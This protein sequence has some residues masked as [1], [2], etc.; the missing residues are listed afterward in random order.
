M[1]IL[2]TSNYAPPHGGVATTV[3]Y[4]A[5]YLS[6]NHEV[7]VASFENGFSDLKQC[8]KIQFTGLKLLNDFLF[9]PWELFTLYFEIKKQ[10]VIFVHTPYFVISNVAAL[11]GKLLGKRVICMSHGPIFIDWRNKLHLPFMNR[12]IDKWLFLNTENKEF[13]EKYISSI[14]PFA[15]ISNGIESEQYKSNKPVTAVQKFIF[16]GRLEQEKGIEEFITIAKEFPSFQFGCIGDGAYKTKLEQL[17]NVK[18]YGYLP[19][20]KA[21]EIMS[22]YDCLLFPSHAESFGLAILEARL[23]GLKIIT[24]NCNSNTNKLVGN[25]GI[26]VPIGDM[27]ALRTAM[28][29]IDSVTSPLERDLQQYDWNEVIKEYERIIF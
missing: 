9:L 22:E 18:C 27:H 29:T 3:Y 13:V 16:V 8:T 2:I 21:I 17:P 6:K 15:Y 25:G 10:D 4:L 11:F 7:S 12:M 5:K 1:K 24:T 23:L 28:K 20:A 19:H 26:V 14:K